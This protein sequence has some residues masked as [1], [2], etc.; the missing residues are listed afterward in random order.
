MKLYISLVFDFADFFA[1]K[2]ISLKLF[3]PTSSS[4][5]YQTIVEV[6]YLF[7]A[8]FADMMRSQVRMAYGMIRI[9]LRCVE[10]L[11]AQIEQRTG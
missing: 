11:L 3:S 7:A 2:Q 1:K 10:F 6:S 9:F 8:R 5:E 4:Y